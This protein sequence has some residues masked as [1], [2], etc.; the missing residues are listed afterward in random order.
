[1]KIKSK[2]TLL[3]TVNPAKAGN[4]EKETDRSPFLIR[5][6]SQQRPLQPPWPLPPEKP[7]CA[8]E[9]AP[10]SARNPPKEPLLP[11]GGGL[12]DRLGGLEVL[13]EFPEDLKLR[14]SVEGALK[15]RSWVTLGAVKDF[16]SP[17]DGP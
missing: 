4:N 3:G 7:P 9:R 10:L 16:L 5:P 14:L 6:D 8:K 11:V 1:M 12:N 2:A 15:D 17:P 13:P